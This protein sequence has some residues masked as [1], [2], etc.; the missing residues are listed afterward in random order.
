MSGYKVFSNKTLLALSVTIYIREGEDP[1]HCYG[2]LK[3]SL[4]PGESRAV[5][6][7]CER[8]AFLNGIK[9][10]YQFNGNLV[11]NSQRVI[12]KNSSFDALLNQN[13]TIVLKEMN[14]MIV[15]AYK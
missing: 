11:H 8:N 1:K 15:G 14:P 12:R 4:N 6:Y 9:V 5:E 10:A 13:S 2:T 7:G 3:I